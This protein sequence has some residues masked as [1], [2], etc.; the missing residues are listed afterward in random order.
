MA[1]SHIF[2]IL[3]RLF[4]HTYYSQSDPMTLST[5]NRRINF[6]C[7]RVKAVR[8]LLCE[9]IADSSPA[10]PAWG[11]IG[12][13]HVNNSMLVSVPAHVLTLGAKAVA[14]LSRVGLLSP[15][16][17]LRACGN[18]PARHPHPRQA[19]VDE[20][21][22]VGG[23]ENAT[24]LQIQTCLISNAPHRASHVLWEQHLGRLVQGITALGRY[25]KVLG[26]LRNRCQ[27]CLGRQEW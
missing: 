4:L 13:G 9:S 16:K 26:H 23:N 20:K 2:V 10:S 7:L 22:T 1:C 17:D 19:T 6:T 21:P 25:Y 8:T 14:L 18:D 24:P 12:F 15:G 27:L 3:T 11:P 5:R